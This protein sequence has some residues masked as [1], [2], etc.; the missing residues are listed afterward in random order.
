M[1]PTSEIDLVDPITKFIITIVPVI[2]SECSKRIH[3][4]SASIDARMEVID[5]ITSDLIRECKFDE[6]VEC[7][8]PIQTLKCELEEQFDEMRD[9]LV[10][11]IKSDLKTEFM[12][13]LTMYVDSLMKEKTVKP[14]ETIPSVGVSTFTISPDA[15]N[16]K[17][18]QMVN[19]S[20]G[21]IA[22]SADEMLAN[23][24]LY[25]RIT[26]GLERAQTGKSQYSAEEL[27]AARGDR[28]DAEHKDLFRAAVKKA[29]FQCDSSDSD[30]DANWERLLA[31]RNGQEY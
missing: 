16:I 25:A 24:P 20:L 30:T 6:N 23:N 3:I 8:T 21:K 9:E 29:D 7:L 14:M 11:E 2:V 28:M 5:A 19:D 15:P 1:N 17:M 13:E 31:I 22:P 27:I 18:G 4:S 12:V 10:S 26:R